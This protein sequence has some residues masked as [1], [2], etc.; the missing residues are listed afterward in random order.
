MD[1]F[2]RKLP[3]SELRNMAEEVNDTF[4]FNKMLYSLNSAQHEEFIK[5]IQAR[6]PSFIKCNGDISLVTQWL[7]YEQRKAIFPLLVVEAKTNK[8]KNN[9]QVGSGLFVSA[10]LFGSIT[11]NVSFLF[12]IS[13]LI[14]SV[15]FVAYLSFRMGVSE[16]QSTPEQDINEILEENARQRERDGVQLKPCKRSLAKQSSVFTPVRAH[17][18]TK[19]KEAEC[20][21]IESDFLTDTSRRNYAN[22]K[23]LG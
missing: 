5:I 4:S 2:M 18:S 16:Y 12:F 13:A 1:G 9:L 10:L 23:S 20:E 14:P 8:L 3:L 22:T 11:F 15:L 17:C 19:S 21:V 6:L 7:T